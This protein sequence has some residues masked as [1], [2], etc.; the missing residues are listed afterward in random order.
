MTSNHSALKDIFL[1]KMR[2]F[3]IQ[4]LSSFLPAIA[5]AAPP[6]PMFDAV[7]KELK[8]V[9]FTDLHFGEGEYKDNH[10]LAIQSLIL[11]MEKPDLV[12]LTGFG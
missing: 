10:S 5:L 9:Q 12:V 7:T 1:K 3:A 11:E 4:F 6:L 2:K 8:I